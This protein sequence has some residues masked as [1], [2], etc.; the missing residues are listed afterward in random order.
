MV[1]LGTARCY[2]RLGDTGPAI[3][4]AQRTLA[5]DRSVVQA[6]QILIQAYL[7]RQQPADA[8]RCV[9]ALAALTGND[10]PT[11][12]QRGR[13]L[14]ALGRLVEAREAFERATALQPSMIEAMLLRREVERS[15]KGVRD[16]V[17]DQPAQST[18]VPHHLSELH[19]ALANGGAREAIEAL[20]RPEYAADRAAQLLLGG[21]LLFEKRAD[22]ALAVYV[23]VAAEPGEHRH[24]AVVG[25]A[26]ALLELDR[27]D[28]AAPLFERATAE[29]PNDL[30]AWTGQARALE[31]LGR[32]ADAAI[33]QR[34]ALAIAEARSQVRSLAASRSR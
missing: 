13:C 4:Y 19:A 21:C 14:F 18:P 32:A 6:H 26:Y 29:E 23:R 31:A 17:G 2:L 11:I 27:A 1:R 5:V 16:A 28:E 30:D 7:Q 8:L 33:A 20:T 9:D 10:A 12:Y 25:T 24:A 22:E 15:L 3:D 34:R